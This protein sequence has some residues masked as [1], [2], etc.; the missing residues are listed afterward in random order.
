MKFLTYQLVLFSLLGACSNETEFRSGRSLMPSV[1]SA[2]NAEA[3]QEDQVVVLNAQS[4]SFMQKKF[5]VGA[6]EGASKV[7]IVWV[8]DESGSMSE[9]NARVSANWNQFSS[10]MRSFADVNLLNSSTAGWSVGSVNGP[11]VFLDKHASQGLYRENS[12]KIVIFVTDDESSMSADQFSDQVKD[13]EL[14]DLIVYAFAGTSVDN[15]RSIATVGRVY[16]ELARRTGGAVYNIC[17][18]NWAPHLEK[19]ALNVE[20]ILQDTYELDLKEGSEVSKVLV[21]M[22]TLST[23]LYEIT[24]GAVRFSEDVL[25]ENDEI[26]IRYKRETSSM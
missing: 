17:D 7:D 3:S 16:E 8:L 6:S 24:D 2:A 1:R 12:K 22:E 20:K 19:L 9:E 10:R 15:C 25:N 13:L 5:V 23:D 26:I 21:N 11:H 4:T 18:E 14:D